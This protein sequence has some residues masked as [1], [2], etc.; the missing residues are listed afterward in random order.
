MT[1][2]VKPRFLEELERR[3][4]RALKLSNSQSLFEIGEGA[5]RLYLRYSRVHERGGT[6]YGLRKEDLL[7]LEGCPSFICFLWDGQAEPLLVPLSE[8]EDVFHGILPASDGQYKVQVYH[9]DDATEFYIARAGRFNVEGHFGWDQ[10]DAVIDSARR[11]AV[12]LFSHSQIQTLLGGIGVIEGY[13]IWIPSNDRVKLDWSVA[14]RFFCRD[15]LPY[16]SEPVGRI[17]QEVDVI[18]LQ[19]GSSEL[20]ALFEVEHSTSIYSALLRFNDLHLVAPNLRPRFSI[21]ANQERRSRFVWQVNRPTFRMSG[22]DK[23]CVFLEYDNV[24]GWYNRLKVRAE[25]SGRDVA[26]T[27]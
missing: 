11:G 1:S 16:G 14:D 19:R 12:P 5:A 2:E 7:Q 9:H 8:Y 13:D 15:F 25:R 4:G 20:K 26:G 18:W 23:V 6:F 3:Y 27:A 17:L 24:F 22:L 21:A 10:L